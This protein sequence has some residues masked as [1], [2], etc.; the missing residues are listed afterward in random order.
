MRQNET[1]SPELFVSKQDRMRQNVLF[2][3]SQNIDGRENGNMPVN[4]MTG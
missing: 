4:G 2:I 1:K 3:L